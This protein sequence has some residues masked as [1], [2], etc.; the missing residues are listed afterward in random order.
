MK[1]LPHTKRS[2]LKIMASLFDPL[3]ILSPFTITLKLLFQSL[4]AGK[5]NW[6]EPIQTCQQMQWQR[7]MDDLVLLSDLKI[8][9]CCFLVASH[10]GSICLHGFSDVSECAYAAVLYLSSTYLDG[11]V[12]VNLLCSKT[13]VVLTKKQTIPCSELLGALILAR[14]VHSVLPCL[15]KMSNVHLWVDSMV[16]L[17]WMHNKRAWKQYVQNHVEEI[18]G[19]TP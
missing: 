2:A 16:I 12:E 5:A 11:H 13:R 14:L 15:P 9:R 1:G 3:G 17:H 8:P 19:L 10:P 4:C 6:D 18:R 7:L